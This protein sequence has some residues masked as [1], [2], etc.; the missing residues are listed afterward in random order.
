MQLRRL[1]PRLTLAGAAALVLVVGLVAPRAAVAA[2]ADE[3]RILSLTNQARASA[4]AGPLVF[5]EGLSITARRWAAAVAA[6]GRISHNP[7]LPIT[8]S[9]PTAIA[10]NVAVGT[11]IQFVHEAFVGSRSHYVNLVNP[12]VTRMGIGVV[13]AGGLVY[14]VQNFLI[15]RGATV[16]T[17]IPTTS[18]SSPI[19]SRSSPVTSPPVTITPGRTP[20]LTP[21]VAPTTT[22]P[23][24]IRSTGPGT[25]SPA[26]TGDAIPS[27]WLSLSF[28]VLRS[29]DRPP[30]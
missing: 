4:G 2:S 14:V 28:D 3:A 18:P 5:D 25:A 30:G 12:T 15:V 20:E 6:A 27:V 13:W 9:G 19:T 7:D 29:W 11:S 17:S 1:G 24:P 23:A 10:E 22:T 8:T 16:P 26:P 21:A